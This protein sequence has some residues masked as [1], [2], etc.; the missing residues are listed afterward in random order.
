MM[1]RW[2]LGPAL[3]C[4]LA[5][6]LLA[7][8][9]TIKTTDGRFLQGDI[10]EN[11]PDG[12]TVSITLH[13]V[14]AAIPRESIVSI[15]YSQNMSEEFHRRLGDLRPDDIAGRLALSRWELQAGQY[16]LAREAALD[17][18]KIDPHNPDAAILLDTI[19]GKQALD[20]RQA[21]SSAAPT[22]EPAANPPEPSKYLTMDD[23]YAIRRAE[24][25]PDDDVRVEFA[26]DVRARYVS[27]HGTLPVDFNSDSPTEQAQD[28]L[29]SG[30]PSLTSDVKIISDPSVLV[31]FKAHVL[32]RVLAGCAAAGC[33][34][35]DSGAGG[36]LLY[37]SSNE[38]LVWYTDFYILQKTTRRLEGGD[39]FGQGPV[40]RPVLDRLHPDSS[41]L[42]QYGLPASIA[43]L[44][45]PNVSGWRPIFRDD[46]DPVYLTISQWIGSLK[47]IVPDYGI[48]FEI[49]AGTPAG[50]QPAAQQLEH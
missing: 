14:T 50:T 37:P 46:Q 9:G 11:S 1:R 6:M 18:Q 16:D 22:T 48:H 29:Q 38:P 5:S 17:A 7:R 21:E 24:L 19:T 4:C 26:N 31:R 39:T 3:V 25:L 15:N 10:D 42:L 13:G 27:T 47:A 20:A 8:Q 23:V 40:I 45:H 28:I 49:P 2:W 32:P 34:G 33:H 43:S 41:L 35:G 12:Q 36:F 30:D 44:P